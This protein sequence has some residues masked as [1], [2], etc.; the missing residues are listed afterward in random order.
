MN[1]TSEINL[2]LALQRMTDNNLSA[3]F[4]MNSIQIFK[5]AKIIEELSDF[6]A[7]LSRFINDK[8]M[9]ESTIAQLR[10]RDN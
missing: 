6:K 4:S 5:T 1:D 9:V 10:N 3:L 7:Y 2:K 8:N